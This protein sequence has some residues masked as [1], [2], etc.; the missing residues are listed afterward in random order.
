MQKP[1]LFRSFT[2]LIVFLFLSGIVI[3]QLINQDAD[4]TRELLIYST[5]MSKAYFDMLI[6]QDSVQAII[7]QPM[8]LSC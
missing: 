8:Q 1:R 3:Y 2:L 5:Q 4:M 7:K 6:K